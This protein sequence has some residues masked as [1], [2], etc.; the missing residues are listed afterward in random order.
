M[1]KN[2]RIRKGCIL[3]ASLQQEGKLAQL[4]GTGIEVDTRK[5]VAEDIL[6]SL[7]TAIAFGNI[8]VIE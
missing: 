8:K 7:S 1:R 3:L 2:M 4:L 6:H 5:V